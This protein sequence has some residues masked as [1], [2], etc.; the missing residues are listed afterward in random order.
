MAACSACSQAC[1][2]TQFADRSCLL[3]VLAGSASEPEGRWS[4]RSTSSS[5]RRRHWRPLRFEAPGRLAP[6]WCAARISFAPCSGSWPVLSDP[7]VA[8][9][10]APSTF[11]EGAPNPSKEPKE[12]TSVALFCIPFAAIRRHCDERASEQFPRLAD[13]FVAALL[14]NY[15]RLGPPPWRPCGGAPPCSSCWRSCCSCIARICAWLA[16]WWRVMSKSSTLL[17]GIWPPGV[18]CSP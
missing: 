2:L 13:C 7:I 18:P 1:C 6:V 16:T 15:I 10:V 9:Q 17:G 14:G 4:T 3:I 11:E 5:R 12:A 8:S